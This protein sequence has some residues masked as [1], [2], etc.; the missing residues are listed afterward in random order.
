MFEHFGIKDIFSGL[1]KFKYWI[2]A[3]TVVGAVAGAFLLSSNSDINT[4]HKE[5]YVSETWYFGVEQNEDSMQENAKSDLRPAKTFNALLDSDMCRGYVKSR[6]LETYSEEEL[7]KLFGKE[8][9]ANGFT[10][11]IMTQNMSH[12]LVDGEESVSLAMKLEDEECVKT[13]LSIY[14]EFAHKMQ[15][16]MQNTYPG[17]TVTNLGTGEEIYVS[18]PDGL[19]TKQATILGAMVGFVLACIVVFFICL[20]VP[21]INRKSDFDEYGLFVLGKVEDIKK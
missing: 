8:G 7:L 15:E 14:D 10:W 2:I 1:W 5:Y 21:T 4:E 6:L 17:L 18:S 11:D 16:E 9:N 12:L 19:S 13:I 3:V 20:W